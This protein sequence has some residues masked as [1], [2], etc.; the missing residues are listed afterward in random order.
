M[1]LPAPGLPASTLATGNRNRA[2]LDWWDRP[3]R[4]VDGDGRGD[5][6]DLVTDDHEGHDLRAVAGGE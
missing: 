6:G 3:E 1:T 2:I 4:V 5:V